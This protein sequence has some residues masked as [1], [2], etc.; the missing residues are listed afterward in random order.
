[1]S[2][3]HYCARRQR[4][5]KNIIK[6]FNMLAVPMSQN[7]GLFQEANDEV[8]VHPI[9]R[10]IKNNEPI[11]SLYCGAKTSLS[12]FDRVSFADKLKQIIEEKK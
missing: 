1:M 8:A 3:T 2:N 5:A 12:Q 6:K 9:S 10:A 4:E 7:V 11:L